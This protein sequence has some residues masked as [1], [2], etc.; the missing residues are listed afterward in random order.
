MKMNT[1]DRKY[2]KALRRV[3]RVKGFY[4]HLVS[5]IL[6]NLLLFLINIMTTPDILWFY[7]PLFGWGI[8]I[9]MH[10][11]F[12]FGFGLWLGQEWEEKKAQ[13]FMDEV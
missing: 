3:R 5:Y 7:W 9:V 4:A 12:V 8:G 2:Q 1:E 11:L 13:E 10:G 6:V